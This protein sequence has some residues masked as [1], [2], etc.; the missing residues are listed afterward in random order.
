MDTNIDYKKILNDYDRYCEN[1][2]STARI[3]H[4][5]IIP[6]VQIIESNRIFN[7][8]KTGK[9]VEGR[10]IFCISLGKGNKKILAWSQM[11]G[12][13]PT[14]TA[15]L[16]DIL[17]FFSQSD[18]YDI[19]RN[20]LLEK[21]Q[22]H[23][24]PMLN[25]DGAERHQRENKLNIDLNRDASRVV[26][27]ESNILRQIADKVKP[28]FGLNLHDQNSYYT[29]GRT[30]NSAAI[31]LLAPP[32]NFD[33]S[34]NEIRKKSM[35][36]I[37]FTYNTLSQF[38]PG[39]IGRYKDDYEPRSF[40]DSFTGEK[41]STILIESGFIKNDFK[42]NYIRK[43]NFISLLSVF[44]SIA[45]EDYKLIDEK[46][47]FTI[48]ENESLLFDLLLRNLI[49][50][51]NGKE[52]KVD[53]GIKREKKF[54]SKKNRF[55][56]KGKIA[57]IGDL[58]FYHGIEEYNMSGYNVKPAAVF[59]GE[60]KSHEDIK[61]NENLIYKGYGYLKLDPFRIDNSYTENKINILP[62]YMDFEPSIAVDEYANLY[63][64]RENQID[65][66][67]INGFLEVVSQPKN[68]ILNGIVIS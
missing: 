26:S 31:S 63:L 25:P 36:V 13:E 6:L 7:T 8:E 10:E 28:E 57:E 46:D 53:I 5:D 35:Q 50:S 51:E 2:L 15:A 52:F 1:S 56:F 58:S 65:Y 16:F 18:E 54:S 32:Y 60:L 23:F 55:Y 29:A 9:S 21:L 4:S 43:M 30:S 11:H 41:I 20:N 22:I 44:N 14:A 39:Q 62:S 49:L 40:G 24:I 42:K 47:Y 67:V 3:T 45:D 38:I 61:Q 34:I 59:E 17:N 48:P 68:S 64:L 37:I 12:D 19:L 27:P 33:K 66:V